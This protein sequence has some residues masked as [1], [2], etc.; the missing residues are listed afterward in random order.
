MIKEK[1]VLELIKDT[2]HRFILTENGLNVKGS[3]VIIA[4]HTMIKMI[5]D[6]EFRK[7]MK[8]YLNELEQFTNAFKEELQEKL[9]EGVND[10][11]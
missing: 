10:N 3:P 2:E 11:E 1:D 5:Q 6:K 9:E 7:Y 8:I 4:R